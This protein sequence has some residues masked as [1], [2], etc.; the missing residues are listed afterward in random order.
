GHAEWALRAPLVPRARLAA[1]IDGPAFDVLAAPVDAPRIDGQ[2][3][4]RSGVPDARL[5]H[6]RR[7]ELPDRNLAP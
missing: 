5:R 3:V 1:G 7:I 4:P 2:V 6:A